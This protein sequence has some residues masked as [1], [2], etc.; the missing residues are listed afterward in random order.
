MQATVRTTWFGI[1]RMKFT[2][3]AAGILL[4]G[5]TATATLSLTDDGGDE[6]RSA[7]RDIAVVEP[8]HRPM[9]R[10]AGLAWQ[11]NMS[12]AGND[13]EALEANGLP[14]APH[15]ASDSSLDRADQMAR[16]F[17]AKLTVTR[18]YF[19]GHAGFINP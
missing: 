8:A 19:P 6:G 4:S 12:R 7:S 18:T 10:G 2:L 17:D 11:H 1:D 14:I 9:E 3:V 15:A 16:F 5:I 13:T